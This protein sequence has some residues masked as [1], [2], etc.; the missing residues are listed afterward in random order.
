MISKRFRKV[1][2]IEKYA[3]L[4]LGQTVKFSIHASVNIL[5]NSITNLI[6]NKQFQL[7]LTHPH[8]FGSLCLVIH[9]EKCLIPL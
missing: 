6:I 2:K 7:P 3:K 1:E 8:I 9:N 4:K 5:M